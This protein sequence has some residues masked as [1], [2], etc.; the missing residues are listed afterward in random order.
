MGLSLPVSLQPVAVADEGAGEKIVGG[1][2]CASV[3][4]HDCLEFAIAVV[5]KHLGFEDLPDPRDATVRIVQYH[6]RS[7][8]AAATR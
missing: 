6:L 4:G 2:R 3:A 7:G 8:D 1:A 5:D